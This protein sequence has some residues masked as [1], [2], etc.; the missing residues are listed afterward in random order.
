[1]LGSK[2]FL[3]SG[4]G[5]SSFCIWPPL[6]SMLWLLLY[7]LALPISVPRSKLQGDPSAPCM[8][9]M[10]SGMCACASYSTAAASIR[11]PFLPSWAPL[12]GACSPWTLTDRLLLLLDSIYRRT[13]IRPDLLA[14]ATA[15]L[16]T[17]AMTCHSR[18]SRG[19]AV[20]S[21]VT[22]SILV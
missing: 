7:A 4:S 17:A 1:L 5:T 16:C 12:A 20:I 13:L 14:C 22:N 9:N 3:H 18:G 2:P 6:L 21:T 19:V 11:L 8:S 15:L 10:L